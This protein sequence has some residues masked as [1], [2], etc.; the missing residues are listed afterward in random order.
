MIYRI[1]ILYRRKY[2]IPKRLLEHIYASHDYCYNIFLHPNTVY[3]YNGGD[4]IILSATVIVR[5]YYIILYLYV[6]SFVI[7]EWEMRDGLMRPKKKPIPNIDFSL[8]LSNLP[9]IQLYR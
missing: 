4:V 6:Y 5:L 7:S 8:R 3:T 2:G 1:I 9:T